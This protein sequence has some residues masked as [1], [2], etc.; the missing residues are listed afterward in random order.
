MLKLNVTWKKRMLNSDLKEMSQNFFKSVGL[1][2]SV[3]PIG[4]IFIFILKKII[5]IAIYK[6]AVGMKFD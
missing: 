6:I 5:S 3:R 2:K 4:E 1:S